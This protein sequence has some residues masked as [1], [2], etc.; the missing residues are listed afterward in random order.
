MV[1]M[2]GEMNEKEIICKHLQEVNDNIDGWIGESRFAVEHKDEQHLLFCSTM[3]N[4][5][6]NTKEQLEKELQKYL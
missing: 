5:W 2:G 6:K 4:I 3:I 1:V